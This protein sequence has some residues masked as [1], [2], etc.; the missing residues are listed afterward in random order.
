M[1][2]PTPP[3]YPDA[4]DLSVSDNL[5]VLALSGLSPAVVTETL[6]ALLREGARIGSLTVLT[7]GRGRRLLKG[8]LHPPQGF[9]WQFF[10][11]WADRQE[12][13]P[14]RIVGLVG[15]EAA[16]VD[17]IASEFDHHVMV[18]TINRV[19]AAMTGPN[20]P[21]VCASI[22]GGRKTMGAALTIAM[23]LHGR[24][25]D[26]LTHVLVPSEVEDGL[27]FF[28]PPRDHAKSPVR[29]VDMPFPRLRLLMPEG[30]RLRPM[31]ELI[32][33][34]QGAVDRRSVLVLEA[35]TRILRLE[36]G[37]SLTLPPLQW[38]VYALLAATATAECQGIGPRDFDLERLLL[39]YRDAGAEENAVSALRG[40][41][42]RDDPA[43]W[44][45]EQIARLKA[46]LMSG[47]GPSVSDA[48]GIVRLGRRPTSRYKLAAPA[49]R[50]RGAS[51]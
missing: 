15:G 2:K 7:T 46:A 23:C 4:P 34:L 49:D 12:P 24:P 39:F 25:C 35:R 36:G 43:P 30:R 42:L 9:L 17:D 32:S 18:E 33:A 45:V 19:L 6:D 41:L 31:P 5:H 21:P 28:F 10:Q 47:L 40:R 22:A 44:L 27:A 16:E 1:S 26:R 48:F 51:R 38:A 8:W 20:D 37:A 29:L 3:G 50:I 11:A 14:C 13:P